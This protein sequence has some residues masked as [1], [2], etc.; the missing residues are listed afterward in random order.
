MN[1]GRIL[2]VALVALIYLCGGFGTEKSA[3]AAVPGMYIIREQVGEG[4]LFLPQLAGLT[5]Q[6]RQAMLNATLREA[7]LAFNNP[8]PDSTLQG[9]FTVSFYN[10]ELLGIHFRGNS[11]TRGTAHPNKIDRGIHLDLSTGQIYEL[12][13]LFLPDID[14]A[15]AIRQQC[16]RNREA[17]RLRIA[18]LWDEWRHEEFVRSW[19]GAD[20]AFLLS[21]DAVRVYSIPR[22][23]TGAISGYRVPYADLREII[24]QSGSLWQKLQAQPNRP[25]AV[26]Q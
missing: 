4:K 2:L 19:R 15:A 9:D 14:F 11:Y 6:E 24:D 8:S 25:I 5:D 21:A 1:K 3:G 26:R 20:A 7:V 13:D 17:Y 10:G 16:D 23:A 22:Y 18:G 12:K